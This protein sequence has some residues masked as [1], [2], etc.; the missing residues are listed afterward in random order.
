MASLPALNQKPGSGIPAIGGQMNVQGALGNNLV[1]MMVFVNPEQLSMLNA[2]SVTNTGVIPSVTNSGIGSVSNS[3]VTTSANVDK[4][5]ITN[6]STDSRA[7][8]A[9]NVGVSSHTDDATKVKESEQE[10]NKDSVSNSAILVK[11]SSFQNESLHAKASTSD[12]T[13]SGNNLHEVEM[14]HQ[15]GQVSATWENRIFAL[16]E[17]KDAD[18]LRGNR[19]ADQRLCFRHLDSTIPPG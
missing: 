10:N 4:S 17:N 13:E 9:D 5:H 18:Q 7:S 12:K 8:N 19:E 1:P 6:A 16:C 15:N 14:N 3:A 2:G 11:N